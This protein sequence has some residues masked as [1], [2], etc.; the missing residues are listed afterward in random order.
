MGHKPN[1]SVKIRKEFNFHWIALV[2]QHVLCFI[3]TEVSVKILTEECGVRSA[4][5]RQ[6]GIRCK[7]R[8][9]QYGLGIK[10]GLGY[11]TRTVD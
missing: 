11:K 4:E 1:E 6:H 10:H 5:R 2:H 8:T 7:T 3:V 9:K